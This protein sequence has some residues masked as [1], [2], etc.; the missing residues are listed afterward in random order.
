MSA[1][2]LP[3][4]IRGRRRSARRKTEIGDSPRIPARAWSGRHFRRFVTRTYTL[5][6]LIGG[7]IQ[8]DAG[9]LSLGGL[10]PE[11]VGKCEAEQAS[12]NYS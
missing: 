11:K 7:C 3:R 6:W 8:I 1:K 12:R 9:S 4:Q 2:G 10:N 5:S